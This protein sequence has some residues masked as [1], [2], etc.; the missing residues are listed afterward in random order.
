MFFTTIQNQ[1]SGTKM[2]QLSPK[3]KVSNLRDVAVAATGPH[4]KIRKTKTRSED[5]AYNLT[6]N[7]K[8]YKRSLRSWFSS[9]R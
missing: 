1:K 5:T 2:Q 7:Y 9:S 4:H 6:T 8:V 3:R